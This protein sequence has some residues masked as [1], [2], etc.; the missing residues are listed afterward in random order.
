MEEVGG[1]NPLG[2]TF[3]GFGE[4]ANFSLRQ[5]VTK[6]VARCARFGLQFLSIVFY[7]PRCLCGHEQFYSRAWACSTSS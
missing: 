4:Y 7:L 1:S 6:L 3:R 5:G 2:S